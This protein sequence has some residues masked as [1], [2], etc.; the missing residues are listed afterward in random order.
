MVR[1]NCIIGTL[2]IILNSKRVVGTVGF[3]KSSDRSMKNMSCEL[4]S[5]V[6]IRGLHKDYVGPLLEGY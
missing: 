3:A 5:K 6:L 1:R 2:F 4:G